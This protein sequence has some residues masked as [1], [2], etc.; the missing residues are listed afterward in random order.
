MS[1]LSI[2]KTMLLAAGILGAA[3]FWPV[4]AE[5]QRTPRRVER[6]IDG[7]TVVLAGGEHVRLLGI[8]APE[9]EPWRHYAQ[10]YGKESTACAGKWMAGKKVLLEHDTERKDKYGRTLAYVYLENGD[11]I[12]RELVAEGCAKARYYAPNGRY[13]KILKE[14]EKTAKADHR[15]LWG[16]P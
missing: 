10:P 4:R 2:F 5:E 1:R 7:D 14:A 6:V 11:L 13:Y 3:G 8:N 9:Y 12:N 15:G 16:G